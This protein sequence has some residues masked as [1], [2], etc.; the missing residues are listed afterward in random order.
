MI[1]DKARVYWRGLLLGTTIG[2][3]VGLPAEGLNARRIGKWYRGA[4]RQRLLGKWGLVSDDTEHAVLT[5]ECLARGDGEVDRFA[6]C[7]GWRLRWWLLALPAEI[8]FATLRGLGKL[9]LGFAPRKSGVFSAGNGPA[10]RAA[11]IG[12]FWA[13]DPAR[14]REHMEIATWM[15]HRDPKALT[16][17]LAIAGIAAW[18]RRHPSSPP[19]WETVAALLGEAGSDPEWREIQGKLARAVDRRQPVAALSRD[20]RK[21]DT[22]EVSGYIYHTVPVAVYAWYLHRGDFRGALEAVWSCGG[23]TDT[24]GAITGALAGASGWDI[25][26]EWV[27]GYRDWPYGQARLSRLADALA[28]DAPPPAYHWPMLA[29]PRNFIFMAIVLVHGLRRFLPPW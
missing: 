27:T 2:D 21:R 25:P 12:G 20:L 5:G 29:L 15:T 6:R 17:A 24:V 7:L 3:S 22:P 9:W 28:G 23:D 8:G 11:V 13:E 26:A 14:L 18:I 4:W 19:A 1:H 10:M 16:G